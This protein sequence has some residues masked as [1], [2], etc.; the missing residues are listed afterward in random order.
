ME[1]VNSLFYMISIYYSSCTNDWK[2][3]VCKDLIQ[4]FPFKQFSV[5]WQKAML[6]MKANQQQNIFISSKNLRFSNLNFFCKYV[7]WLVAYNYW[8]LFGGEESSRVFGNLHTAIPSFRGMCTGLG[9]KRKIILITFIL[10][11]TLSFT[12]SYFD[13]DFG[14]TSPFFLVFVYSSQT[15]SFKHSWAYTSLLSY[16]LRRLLCFGTYNGPLVHRW[17]GSQHMVKEVA[18]SFLY[19]IYLTQ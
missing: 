3:V 15:T 13:H 4:T 17:V 12:T 1:T 8:L 14:K 19:Q 2:I 16:V 18:L 10:I 6:H 5:D 11:L 9:K 7:N